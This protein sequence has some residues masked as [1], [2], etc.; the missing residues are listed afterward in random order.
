MVEKL[1]WR[2]ADHDPRVISVSLVCDI[3]QALIGKKFL[4]SID[5]TD[6]KKK[7]EIT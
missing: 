1:V 2:L 6:I 3:L 4:K 5:N 7:L